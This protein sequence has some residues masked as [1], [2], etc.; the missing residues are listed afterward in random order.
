METQVTLIH[1]CALSSVDCISVVLI[2]RI[3]IG[4][5]RLWGN[6]LTIGIDRF[7]NC[8]IGLIILYKLVLEIKPNLCNKFANCDRILQFCAFYCMFVVIGI[9]LKYW[10][11]GI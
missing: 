9:G 6:F 7:Y 1:V 4:N 5:S 11:S 8:T 10:L 2:N 3:T